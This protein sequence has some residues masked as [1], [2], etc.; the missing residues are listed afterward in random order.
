MNSGL[1]SKKR[2]K[3][4]AVLSLSM[5]GV[6]L[7][8]ILFRGSVWTQ[9]DFKVLD[10]F[11]RK[12][13]S[14]GR[15]PALSSQIVY[16]LVTD[17]TYKHFKKNVLDRKDLAEVNRI[18]SALAPQA[19]AYD[20][21]FARPGR[22]D[23]DRMFSESLR[24]LDAVYLPFGLACTKENLP[25]RWETGSAFERLRDQYLKTPNQNGAAE[26]FYANRA[27]MQMDRLSEAA[28]N[29]GHISAIADPDGIYRHM[30]MVV[31]I[32]NG[33]VPTLALSILLDYAG[34]D[35]RDIVIDWGRDIR[36]PAASKGH[37]DTDIR[38]PIDQQGRAFIPFARKWNQG[39]PK[40]EAHSLI[41]FH[42]DEN[43]R[44]NLF[45]FFE[46]NF[47]F[48]GDVSTGA[49]DIGHTPLE[50]NA[51]LIMLHTALLN[52]MLTHTFYGKRT[53][54]QV[55]TIICLAAFLLAAAGTLKSSWVLYLSGVLIMVGIFVLAWFQF[56]RFQ[57]M[58]PVTIAA[59]AFLVF[60]GEVIGIGVAVHR[61][62]AFIRGA[63][64]RYIP[65]SVVHEL[66]ENPQLLT[67]GG[68]ERTVTVLFSDLA[69]FTAIS[70]KIPPAT[71]VHI[72]NS[73]L[74]EMT[75]IV[76][77]NGGIIDKYQGD[78]IMAEF[79]VPLSMPDHAD[80]AVYA[81]LQMHRRL[82]RL[83]SEWRKK[84]SPN[85]KC[86][87]GINT[88]PM[89]V[90]NM[91]SQQ[92]FD[93]TVIGDAVNLASR[94]EGANKR[95]NTRLMISEFTFNTL[96]PGLFRTRLLDVIRVK[97]KSKAVKVFEVYG[98]MSEPVDPGREKYAQTYHK[99][100]EAYLSRDFV[101]ARRFF[102]RAGALFPEDPACNN[103]VARIDAVDPEALPENWDGAITLNTK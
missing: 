50:S 42:A 76:L 54:G 97:G 80:R 5:L 77:M 52:G 95:Y 93:Y 68:E 33:Y 75:H 31:K 56:L 79:G 57:L 78:A 99:G 16:L 19:V 74:T 85:L 20:I 100:V 45:D 51:P 96:S 41:E 94:L 43:L 23:A 58:P 98:E 92:V 87:I 11:Y 21:I 12:A 28:P 64:S 81:G 89:I 38:I 6:V 13:A 91:G 40:M 18:L 34:V 67:L 14:M 46:G 83:T 1:K 69:D 102:Q 88:G 63:F 47:V 26:P 37:L 66:L 60:W 49:S 55:L 17:K 27:L 8:F 44:G 15:A 25:F 10:F 7:L 4:A 70:E 90:G 53:S 35:F 22:P 72:L 101:S 84:G 73:Y 103:M 30:V 2:L 82:D 36:I 48:I 59:S 32:D 3:L 62:R 71:L 9:W 39:F 86:R 65:E 24:R 29:A 61:E